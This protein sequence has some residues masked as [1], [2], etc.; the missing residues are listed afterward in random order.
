MILKI[1]IWVCTKAL[2]FLVCLLLFV[3]LM[4]DVWTKYNQKMTSTGENLIAI[5]LS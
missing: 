2:V 3:I 5:I 4:E 1:S